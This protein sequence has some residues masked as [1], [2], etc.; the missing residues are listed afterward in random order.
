MVV[1]ARLLMAGRVTQRDRMCGAMGFRVG[2][3]VCLEPDIE[4]A[5]FQFVPMSTP[6]RS[7]SVHFIVVR[8][9]RAS[10]DG[11]TP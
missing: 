10:A 1:G 3:L 4:H 6:L 9:R 7:K 8:R 11:G 5:N 2:A